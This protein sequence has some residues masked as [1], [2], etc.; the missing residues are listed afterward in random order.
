MNRPFDFRG[1]RIF[2][3]G[4][5]EIGRARNI[6]VRSMNVDSG[7]I[8]EL[9]IPRGGNAVLS[10]GTRIDFLDFRAN[11]QP[12]PDHSLENSTSYVNPVARLKVSRAGERPAM[13]HAFGPDLYWYPLASQPAAGYLFQLV[14]FEKVSDHHVL[15]VQWD[16]GA[17]VVYAGCALLVIALA[18]VFL[19]S[20]HRVWVVV[21]HRD[22]IINITAAGHS[23]RHTAS[24]ESKV[25]KLM[26]S[27][28][29]S[30]KKV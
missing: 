16:P 26:R 8:A 10:D 23:N 21:E 17:N 12:G 5:A 18:G 13:A 11:F 22:T 7:E 2:Q 3:A 30:L 29:R 15:A 6:K 4:S 27:I 1:Y 9:S 28:D 19:F 14:D 25:A 24:L 20:H